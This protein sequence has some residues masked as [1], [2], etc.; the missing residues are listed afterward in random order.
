MANTPLPF[1]NNSNIWMYCKES[2]MQY[3][4]HLVK[5]CNKKKRAKLA[6]KYKLPSANVGVTDMN[7]YCFMIDSSCSSSQDYLSF[8]DGW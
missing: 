1:N 4:R 6:K 5:E 7:A 2:D 3:L 8:L